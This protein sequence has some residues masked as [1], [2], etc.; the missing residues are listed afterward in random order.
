MH[1]H[2]MTPNVTHNFKKSYPANHKWEIHKLY[3]ET[4]VNV[5]S[6]TTKNFKGIGCNM[7]IS[8]KEWNNVSFW[9]TCQENNYQLKTS[10][11]KIH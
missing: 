6:F 3:M 7:T 1:D 8:Q 10:Q 4:K 2:S 9:H 11:W 5:S